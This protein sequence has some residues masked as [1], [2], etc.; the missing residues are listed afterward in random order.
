LRILIADDHVLV[1]DTLGAFLRRVDGTVVDMVASQHEAK[2]AVAAQAYD[3]VLLDYDMPGMNGI[4]GL[5]EVVAHAGG[6]PVALLTGKVS[7]RLAELAREAGAAGFL[8]KTLPASE[9]VDAVGTMARGEGFFPVDL[10]P[11]DEGMSALHPA[12]VDR[13][14][15]LSYDPAEAAEAARTLTRR[16]R[17]VLAGICEGK[18]N[19]E[20]ARDLDLQEVTIKL[21]VKTLTRKL[22]AK[23]RTHAAMIARDLRMF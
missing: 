17:H 14:D 15:G 23:N 6:A 18:S 22:K 8:P 1:R 7:R 11:D 12:D 5:E 2:D 20:I 10:L 13:L 19:K 3:L 21:Y 9:L 4:A 16:E